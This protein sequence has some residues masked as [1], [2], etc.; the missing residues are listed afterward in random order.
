M[1]EGPESL[2]LLLKFMGWTSQGT[3]KGHGPEP[4][5]P[6]TPVGRRC[7]A[8]RRAGGPRAKEEAPRLRFPSDFTPRGLLRP[9]GRGSTPAAELDE[10]S[11]LCWDP[12]RPPGPCCPPR[13]VRAAGVQEARLRFAGPCGGG[14]G[15][16]PPLAAC[17][18]AS[19]WRELSWCSGASGPAAGP[20]VG[21]SRCD[22]LLEATPLPPPC[23]P[24]GSP[25]EPRQQAP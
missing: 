13:L 7:G 3:G 11:V 2:A 5:G 23:G 16:L 6:A 8:R 21:V 20:R 19:P 12:V 24:G 18:P 4:A 14:R 17:P 9:E 22:T 15:S 10:Q 25:R 1:R